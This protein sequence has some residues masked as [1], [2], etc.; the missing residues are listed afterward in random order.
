MNHHTAQIAIPGRAPFEIPVNLQN[1][2]IFQR[3]PGINRELENL[4]PSFLEAFATGEKILRIATFRYLGAVTDGDHPAPRAI[5]ATMRRV[6][7]STKRFMRPDELAEFKKADAT[8]RKLAGVIIENAIDK[9]ALL[10]PDEFRET[11]AKYFN[12]FTG[13]A[14]RVD[15][16]LMFLKQMEAAIQRVA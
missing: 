8:Y 16:L 11:H 6:A 4:T 1:V 15:L 7:K 5:I 12:Q 10:L 13:R 9:F 2:G 3:L 14:P